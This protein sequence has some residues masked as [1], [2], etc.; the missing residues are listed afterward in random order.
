MWQHGSLVKNFSRGDICYW[1][2]DFFIEILGAS[3]IYVIR[4]GQ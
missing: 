1:I 3:F 4:E 2:H